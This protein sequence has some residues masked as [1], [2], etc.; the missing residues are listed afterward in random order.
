VRAFAAEEDNQMR[1]P[2]RFAAGVAAVA[3]VATTLSLADPAGA[4]LVRPLARRGN[5]VSVC[6]YSHTAPDDPIVHPG[7]PGASHSHDF[8]ANTSTDAAATLESLQASGTT[9]KN[10][11]N[12]TAAYW[13]PTL[14]DAGKVV[15]PV[16]VRSYYLVAGRDPST[17]KPF[18]T[19]LKIVAGAT[20]PPGPGANHVEWACVG[21]DDNGTPKAAPPDC[22]SG[23]HLVMRIHF[24]DCWDGHN[25]D[26]ADHRSHM[27]YAARGQCPAGYPVAVPHLR[28]GVNYPASVRGSEVTLS[29]GGPDTAHADF[30]NAWKGDAQARLVRLCLNTARDCGARG[31]F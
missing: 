15:Q 22:P 7:Q 26:S 24:P 1:A 9:C 27:A 8:F 5:F 18:P 12:D 16:L 21:K 25:L 28:I 31:P 13:V 4:T 20:L 23:E 19:G 10:R 29:S 17:I 2:S 30:F 6:R 11:P 14:S 3:A